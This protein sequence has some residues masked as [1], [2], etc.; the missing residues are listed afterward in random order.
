MATGALSGGLDIRKGGKQA[1][2]VCVEKAFAVPGGPTAIADNTTTTVT[3]KVPNSVAVIS[4]LDVAIS[5]GGPGPTNGLAPFNADYT[6]TLRHVP[7]GVEVEL[8]SEIGF[9]DDG[10]FVRLDDEATED[11]GTV[12]DDPEDFPVIGVYN[13]EGAAALADFDGV[14]A[15]G[16]WELE[17]LDDNS[18][19]TGRLLN[20]TL[21]I[22]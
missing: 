10:I 17:I 19:L 11:I 4:D 20:W 1:A 5:I 6:V 14:L 16:T 21:H 12:P 18:G 8:F 15:S 9:D 2:A 3:M 7:S 22:K 13:P